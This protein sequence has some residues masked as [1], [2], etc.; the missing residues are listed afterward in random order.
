M[1]NKLAITSL[2]ISFILRN[3][4]FETLL[5][6]IVIIVINYFFLYFY[7]TLAYFYRI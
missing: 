2:L 7:L 4:G 3:T 5:S 6:N 1:N